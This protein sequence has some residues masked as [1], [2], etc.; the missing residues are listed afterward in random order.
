MKKIITFL[1]AAVLAVSLSACGD[2]VPGESD[3]KKVWK[4]KIAANCDSVKL[5]S[6]EKLNGRPTDSPTIYIAEMHF[7]LEWEPVSAIDFPKKCKFNTRD[8]EFSYA[9]IWDFIHNN[10]WEIAKT[11]E[12]TKTIRFQKT[13][14][15]WIPIELLHSRF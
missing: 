1:T 6:V 9:R 4:K 8:P 3:F 12:Y 15:G 5:L 11:G 10:G 7:K 13:E 2:D 14:N